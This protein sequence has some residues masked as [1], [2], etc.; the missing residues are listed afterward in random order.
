MNESEGSEKGLV[1]RELRVEREVEVGFEEKSDL[2][3][4][5]KR[6]EAE[7][8]E[9]AAILAMLLLWF[10]WMMGRRGTMTM[11]LK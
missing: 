5:A 2:G 6:E 11:R 1:G 9:H 10:V 4:K 7:V 3:F 8:A